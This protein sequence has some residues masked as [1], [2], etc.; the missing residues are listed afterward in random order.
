MP[1]PLW[2]WDAPGKKVT[3]TFAGQLKSATADSSGRWTIQLDALK[4]GGP[5]DLTVSGSTT[6][7]VRN[8]LVGEVWLGSG[9][10]NMQM[11]VRE[12]LDGEKETAAAKYPRI[13]LAYVPH[14]VA[15]EPQPDVPV[16]W[17]ECTSETVREFS[18][19]MYFF[20]RKLHEDLNCPIG[21]IHDSWT[22]SL[23][24]P[25]IS[26]ETLATVPE[27]RP[28]LDAW[29]QALAKRGDAEKASY[30]AFQKEF[31]DWLAA[32]PSAPHGRKPYAPQLDEPFD[33]LANYQQPT[34]LYNGMIAPV[35]PF[36]IRGVLWCQGEGNSD[37]SAQYGALFPALIR[38]WRRAWG[39]GD[40]PFL[41]VQ[42]SS[43]RAA[44][45]EPADSDWAQLREVQT[46]TLRVPNTAMAMSIDVGEEKDPHYRDKQTVSLRLALAAEAMIHGKRVAYRPPLYKSFAVEDGAVRIAFTDAAGLT[47]RDGQSPRMFQV[48]AADRKWFWADANIEGT[49]IVV[50]SDA[51][52][53]PVAV[54]YAWADNALAA[55]VVNADGLPLGTFRTDDWPV[56][57]EGALVWESLLDYLK[58]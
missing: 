47:T 53:A 38:D 57:T 31:S 2:G 17:V 12:C 55:N 19:I 22:G 39:Q 56:S 9:Q 7:T 8:V 42:T 25:W 3:V 16:E 18:A 11:R 35:A 29:Q 10:S 46:R 34:G 23:I 6:R 50:R 27:A 30:A 37:R 49:T 28:Q 54:R 14:V 45:S 52:K 4:T 36:A 58:K 24:E 26:R 51:V 32:W 43:Y 15:H 40:F 21:L 1:V 20:G 13:R 41:F 48:A 44:P 33:P 5:F